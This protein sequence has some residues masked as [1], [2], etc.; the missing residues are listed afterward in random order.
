MYWLLAA[1]PTKLKAERE[2][3]EVRPH[4][5]LNI[6]HPRDIFIS[7]ISPND[8][9]KKKRLHKRSFPVFYL[10]RKLVQ[11]R[12][13]TITPRKNATFSEENQYICIPQMTGMPN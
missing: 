11:L 10:A 6:L 4:R 7:S 13:C 2:K 12:Y 9:Q 5:V 8:E 3:K 1:F